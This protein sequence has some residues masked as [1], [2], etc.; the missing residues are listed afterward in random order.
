MSNTKNRTAKIKNR[1][2]NGIRAELWGSNPHSN[3]VDFSKL[4]YIFLL[5][6]NVAIMIR[7]GNKAAVTMAINIITIFLGKYI[8]LMK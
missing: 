3:G 5:R 6:N 7:T 2:E 1:K 4:L 8:L